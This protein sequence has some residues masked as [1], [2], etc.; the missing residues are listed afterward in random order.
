MNIAII[1][2]SVPLQLHMICACHLV[3]AKHQLGYI[4]IAINGGFKIS[5]HS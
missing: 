1:L 3:E 5:S 2:F 4:A